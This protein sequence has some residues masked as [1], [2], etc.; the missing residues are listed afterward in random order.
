MATLATTSSAP[1]H[2]CIWCRMGSCP[3]RRMHPKSAASCGREG[4]EPTVAAC[5]EGELELT[6]ATCCEGEFEPTVAAWCGEVLEPP[7]AA[8]G[9]SSLPPPVATFHTLTCRATLPEMRCVP[10]TFVANK[11]RCCVLSLSSRT[12]TPSRATSGAPCKNE[13]RDPTYWRS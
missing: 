4:L 12:N 2:W 5:C 9:A 7:V 6:V 1:C 11:I 13:T 10:R 8:C 3:S